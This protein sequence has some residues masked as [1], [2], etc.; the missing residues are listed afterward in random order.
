MDA[1]IYYLV[2][3]NA[4]LYARRSLITR[5]SRR[6]AAEAGVGRAIIFY[7]QVHKESRFFALARLRTAFIKCNVSALSVIKLLYIE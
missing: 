1:F 2:H 6:G 4:L 7:K 5:D 3:S